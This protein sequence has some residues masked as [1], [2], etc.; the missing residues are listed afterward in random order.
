MCT[1][2]GVTSLTALTH[3]AV[4]GCN[5]RQRHLP[6]GA[7]ELLIDPALHS[8]HGCAPYQ[9]DAT[10]ELHMSGPSEG[11]RATKRVRCTGTACISAPGRS[12]VP[13][14]VLAVHHLFIAGID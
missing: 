11:G 6:D 7:V 4:A 10:A 13:L 3:L 5:V 9:V 1:I 12:I 2:G 8:P 14:K